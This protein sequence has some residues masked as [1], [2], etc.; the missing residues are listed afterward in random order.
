M[1]RKI[2]TILIGAQKAGSSS[3]YQWIG[4]HPDVSAPESLK[5]VHYFTNDELYNQGTTFFDKFYPSKIKEKIIL[6]GAVNYILFDKCAER[7]HRY[8]PNLKLILIL[9]NPVN[10][11]FSAYTYFKKQQHEKRSFKDALK[12][13]QEIPYTTYKDVSNLTYLEHGFYFKQLQHFIKYFDL[14]NIHIVFYEELMADKKNK[15][16]QIF[17]FLGVEIDFIPDFIH[18]NKTGSVRSG[19]LNNILFGSNKIKNFVKKYS[20]YNLL[21]LKFKQKLKRKLSEM[22]T[23]DAKKSIK[24]TLDGE[25][26]AYLQEQYKEDVQCL[27]NLLKKDLTSL[28]N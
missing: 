16:A 27:S 21:P 15:C 8:D 2:N 23:G 24:E 9:R 28:W 4:Q 1:E 17:K 14:E 25:T 10:R 3:L 26:K 6:H 18:K 5:D 7:L 22:N 13:E 20:L 12:Q 11:A 19:K